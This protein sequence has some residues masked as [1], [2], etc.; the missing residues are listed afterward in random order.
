MTTLNV[1]L[2][3][4]LKAFI[5]AQVD[6]GNYASTSEFVLD[7]I[8]RDHDRRQLRDALFEGACSQLGAN[9]DALYFASLRA[10]ALADT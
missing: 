3:D 6:Q 7:L 8:R 9:A 4:E 1:S 5:D 2:S 10:R